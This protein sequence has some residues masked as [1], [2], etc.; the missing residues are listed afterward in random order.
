MF[1]ETPVVGEIYKLGDWKLYAIH[2]DNN[3]KGFFGKYEW[4]SNFHKCKTW[5]EGGLY[6]SSEN[7][8]QAAKIY[9]EY[10]V[11]TLMDC[12]PAQSKKLWKNY[13]RIDGSSEEWDLRKYDV[14]STIL[15]DKFYR[16]KELRKKLIDTGDK[17]LEET[18]HWGDQFWGVDIKKGGQNNLGKVLMK[19]REFWK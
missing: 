16:N 4:L 17:F 9:P 19:I 5:F 11:N 8:Y 7:A 18:N 2:D 15:F 6:P 13:T 14:M 3:I 1:N 10:R 12:T